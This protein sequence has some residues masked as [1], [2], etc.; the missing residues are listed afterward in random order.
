MGG[1]AADIE[2][3]SRAWAGPPIDEEKACTL[4]ARPGRLSVSP[5][6]PDQ[7]DPWQRRAPRGR[8]D[9]GW[10]VHPPPFHR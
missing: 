2:S 3:A 5:P 8:G 7:S 10:V 4:M 1:V 6:D 9:G